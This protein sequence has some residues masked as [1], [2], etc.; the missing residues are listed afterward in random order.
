MQY[1]VLYIDPICAACK[2]TCSREG[3]EEEED[4][5]LDE[6]SNMTTERRVS[7]FVKSVYD[8]PDW[9]SLGHFSGQQEVTLSLQATVSAMVCAAKWKR[10]ALGVTDRRPSQ[11]PIDSQEVEARKISSIPA[12]LPGKVLQI[13]TEKKRLW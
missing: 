12:F 8:H 1:Q 4:I 5:T 7:N 10:K 13:D 6:A 3:Q 9:N 11:Q 2:P